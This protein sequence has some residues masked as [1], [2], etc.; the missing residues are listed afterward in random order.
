MPH[1]LH[2]VLQVLLVMALRI[3]ILSSLLLTGDSWC[4]EMP[5]YFI[6]SFIRSLADHY[7]PT[8]MTVVY[9]R[10]DDGEIK[11]NICSSTVAYCLGYSEDDL[12][13][14]VRIIDSCFA[15]TVIFFM[16]LNTTNLLNSLNHTI[17]KHGRQVFVHLLESAA[18]PYLKV[19]NKVVFYESTEGGK[20]VRLVDKYIPVKDVVVTH[21]MGTWTYGNGIKFNEETTWNLRSNLHGVVLRTAVLKW[22]PFFDYMLDMDGRPTKAKGFLMATLHE[23]EA[24][25]NFTVSLSLPKDGEWGILTDEGE[26]TG[27]VGEL[28]NREIDI[29]PSGLYRIKWREQIIDFA[30]PVLKDLQTLIARESSGKEVNITVYLEI[31]MPGAW[32]LVCLSFASMFCTIYAM[33]LVNYKLPSNFLDKVL[34]SMAAT[35]RQF[36]QIPNN[37]RVDNV[38]SRMVIIVF[39]LNSYILF[40][41]Y[42]CN[43]TAAMTST[44]PNSGIASFEDAISSGYKVVVLDGTAHSERVKD[45]EL[46]LVM[47]TPSSG[48]TP[49]EQILSEMSRETKVLNFGSSL[50][51]V[52]RHDFYPLDI[53]EASRQMVA[54]GLQKGS[55][56]IDIFNYNIQKMDEAGIL[57]SLA[58]EYFSKQTTSQTAVEEAISLGYDNVLFPCLVLVSGCA[59]SLFI[60][61]SEIIG[62]VIEKA[63]EKNL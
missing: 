9:S 10:Q 62:R 61:S 12:G 38:S 47:L 14:A 59:F 22:P 31:F 46:D 50:S 32:V 26:Y 45:T 36:I 33:G 24:I 56:Y 49:F 53:K 23:L 43:L 8:P 37:L 27:L 54:F 41:Y 42:T 58:E 17:F 5:Q 52:G 19:D 13:P 57:D 15:E 55:E 35:C 30:T 3:Y 44:A 29:A 39:A 11:Q 63:W 4:N 25:L 21:N 40:T 6:H 51:F 2:L 60:F 18:F 34:L 1:F 16:G 20:H 48:T 7:Q 28:V